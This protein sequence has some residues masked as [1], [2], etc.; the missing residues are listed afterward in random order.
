MTKRELIVPPE[1]E[2]DPNA[3]ELVRVWAAEGEQHVTLATGLWKDPGAWGIVLVDLAR[4]VANAYGQTH[5]M[6][7]ESVL[8]RIRECFDAEWTAPTGTPTGGLQE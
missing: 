4:H 6:E 1:A 5:G 7:K 2:R 3:W 8:R